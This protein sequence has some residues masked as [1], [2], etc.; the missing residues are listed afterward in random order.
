MVAPLAAERIWTSKIA[1]RRGCPAASG[2][3][4]TKE[5]NGCNSPRLVEFG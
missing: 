3:V 4:E 1:G 2:V 5:I